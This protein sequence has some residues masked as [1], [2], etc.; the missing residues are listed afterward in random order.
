MKLWDIS[1]MK[2]KYS[3]HVN[4]S[5]L[6]QEKNMKVLG[7]LLLTTVLN[8]TA[9]LRALWLVKPVKNLCGTSPSRH[10]MRSTTRKNE[11][12]FNVCLMSYRMIKTENKILIDDHN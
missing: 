11:E 10:G 8:C 1:S 6:E 3:D 2:A 4:L 9:I 5:T 7:K 12:L